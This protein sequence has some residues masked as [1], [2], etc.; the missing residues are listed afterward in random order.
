M[1]GRSLTPFLLQVLLDT[2]RNQM[3]GHLNNFKNPEYRRHVMRQIELEREQQAYLSSQAAQLE[4]QVLGFLKY[5]FN[6]FKRRSYIF[7]NTI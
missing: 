4:K 6:A 5:N 1:A 2:I 3:M 7:K